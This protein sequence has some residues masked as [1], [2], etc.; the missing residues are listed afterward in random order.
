MATTK[1]KYVA[2]GVHRKD[3]NVLRGSRFLVNA[4]AK[5]APRDRGGW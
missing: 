1:I 2:E 5:S 4:I 3:R